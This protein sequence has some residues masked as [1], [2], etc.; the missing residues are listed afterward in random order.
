M[1]QKY[2][3]HRVYTLLTNHYRNYI[4]GN[5]LI[6]VGNTF[7]DIA[8]VLYTSSKQMLRYGNITFGY[9]IP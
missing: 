3:I 6:I 1:I 9:A 4:Q 7:I 2:K 8:K 5:I